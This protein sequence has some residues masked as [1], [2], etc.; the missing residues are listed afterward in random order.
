MS[1]AVTHRSDPE[2]C[3]GSDEWATGACPDRCEEIAK[4]Y[5]EKTEA[6]AKI[7]RTVSKTS[8]QELTSKGAKIRSTYVSFA[9]KEK[10]RLEEE[11][12]AKKAEIGEKEEKVAETKGTFLD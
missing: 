3:D 4:A 10:K 9:V 11:I 5:R 2:C 12:V 6:A 8:W 7:R 1:R